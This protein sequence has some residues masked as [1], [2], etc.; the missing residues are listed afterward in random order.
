MGSR[1]AGKVAVVT[2]GGSGIGRAVA[3]LL[4]EEGAS[5]VV[6]DAG[7]ETPSGPADQVAQE[8]ASTGGASL[9]SRDDVSLMSGAESVIQSALDAYGRLDVLV[10]SADAPAP[11][12]I[13]EMMPEDFDN[14]V[15]NNLRGTFMPCKFASVHFRQQRSGRIVN[16][17]SDAGLGGCRPFQLRRR[18]GGHRRAH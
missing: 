7:P 11:R 8:I 3:L 18:L 10:N 1:F 15:R 17:T 12:G 13:K 2:G 16:I 4:A 6:N 5:V 14:A 9:A